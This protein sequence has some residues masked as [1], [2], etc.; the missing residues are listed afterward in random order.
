[1]LWSIERILILA[2]YSF[3]FVILVKKS[4]DRLI[5]EN[6]LLKDL[7]DVGYLDVVV[8]DLIRKNGYERPVFTETVTAGA[9]DIA[10]DFDLAP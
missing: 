4:V 1:M 2:P 7:F 8:S 10:L 9:L 6:A 5:A 3:A